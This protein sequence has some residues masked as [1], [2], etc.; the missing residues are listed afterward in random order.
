MLQIQVD[1]QEKASAMRC[2]ED[3]IVAGFR[4]ALNSKL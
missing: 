3:I 4:I 1:V 2:G